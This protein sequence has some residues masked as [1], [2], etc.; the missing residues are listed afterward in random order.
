[1]NKSR[2]S[3][4][5]ALSALSALLASTSLQAI[6]NVPAVTVSSLGHDFTPGV[7]IEDIPAVVEDIFVSAD[8]SSG[9]AAPS[10]TA[11]LDSDTQ[12]RYTIQA[13]VGEKFL[14]DPNGQ[15]ARFDILLQHNSPLASPGEFGTL[16]T[17]VVGLTDYEGAPTVSFSIS[18]I[19]AVGD[20][21]GYFDF[22]VTS[23]SFSDAIAFTA[24]TMTF[25]YPTRN[26]GSG[27]LLFSP[28]DNGTFS[29]LYEGNFA[30]DPGAFTSIVPVATPVPE[31]AT[32]A[33][34]LGLLALG[35]VQFRKR[36]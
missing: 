34:I 32:Y 25:T 5:I 2:L 7:P 3:P 21:N 13:P 9:A 10:W 35:W 28:R 6:I 20:Q 26:T 19:G 23:S 16:P 36:R 22:G 27:P 31:P 30:S 14:I 17:L 12:L 4:V 1:M 11:D 33:A 18:G 8:G 29:V 24:L 15:N